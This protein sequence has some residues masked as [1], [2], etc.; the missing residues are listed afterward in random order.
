VFSELSCILDAYFMS[1]QKEMKSWTKDEVALFTEAFRFI[2]S[3]VVNC[4][5]N[6]DVIRDR[7]RIIPNCMSFLKGITTSNY[8]DDGESLSEEEEVVVAIRCCLQAVANLMADNEMSC[9]VVVHQLN[10]A[11]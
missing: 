10:E 3:S 11:M 4:K 5:G 2:R 7:S 6:Q 8:G 9:K 1:E